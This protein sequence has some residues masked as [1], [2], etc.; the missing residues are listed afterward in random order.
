MNVETR[1]QRIEDR[2]EIKQLRHRYAYAV[3]SHDWET[4]QTL[5]TDD[6][7]IRFPQDNAEQSA[8]EGRDGLEAFGE[9]MDEHLIFSAHMMH[10]PVI[11]VKG[12]TAA[13]TWY[14]EVPEVTPQG[15]VLIHGRYE[16]EYR[17]TS[18]GWR[19]A[20]VDIYYNFRVPADD[21]WDREAVEPWQ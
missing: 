16:D 8:F 7:T 4:F 11:D 10:N 1:L 14:A 12:D 6:A 17:R 2:I 9:A 18:G 20:G 5:F 13:G 3:D 21:A 19:F 15:S